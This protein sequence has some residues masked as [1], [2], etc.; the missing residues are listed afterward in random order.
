MTRCSHPPSC[1]YDD[2]QISLVQ[3]SDVSPPE[4]AVGLHS[5]ANRENEYMQG[6]LVPEA[7]RMNGGVHSLHQEDFHLRYR[8]SSHDPAML[9]LLQ[10][11]VHPDEDDD[12]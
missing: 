3:P 8:R 6:L 10:D 5:D 2:S 11:V 9:S 7:V 4:A 1:C 12:G